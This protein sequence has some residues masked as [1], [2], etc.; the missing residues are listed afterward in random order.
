[1]FLL[2]TGKPVKYIES[3]RINLVILYESLIR[4]QTRSEYFVN[5]Q[6]I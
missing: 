1:M 5:R 2:F 4:Y 3:S 6:E